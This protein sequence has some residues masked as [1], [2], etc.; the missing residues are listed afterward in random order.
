LA[1]ETQKNKPKESSFSFNY[2]RIEIVMS[3]YGLKYEP[4]EVKE[5]IL[6]AF[7]TYKVSA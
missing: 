1:K 7:E 2:D 4:I 3:L 6:K 5:L